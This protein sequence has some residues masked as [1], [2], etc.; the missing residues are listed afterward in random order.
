M[1][2][3]VESWLPFFAAFTDA[4]ILNP[5]YA[6]HPANGG[7]T[8]CKLCDAPAGDD[9]TAHL[10]RHARD[11]REHRRRQQSAAARARAANLRK[12]RQTRAAA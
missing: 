11:L 8:W 12:A 3:T 1:I 10:A 2:S 5:S 7:G 4:Q 6:L 9:P